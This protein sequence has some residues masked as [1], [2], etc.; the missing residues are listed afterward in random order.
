L[1]L[2]T[3][4]SLQLEQITSNAE[5]VKQS[6]ER[7]TDN[8]AREVLYWCAKAFSQFRRFASCRWSKSGKPPRLRPIPRDCS[9]KRR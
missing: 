8:N 9:T 5:Y 2:E 1:K 7:I 6:L 3:K 4:R